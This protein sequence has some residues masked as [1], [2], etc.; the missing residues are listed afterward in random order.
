[1][2]LKGVQVLPEVP[3]LAVLQICQGCAREST[4]STLSEHTQK[5]PQRLTRSHTHPGDKMVTAKPQEG[6]HRSLSPCS[7]LYTRKHTLQNRCWLYPQPWQ[8]QSRT[9]GQKRGTGQDSASAQPGSPLWG[10]LV[11]R[12]AACFIPPLCDSD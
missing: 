10:C 11:T 4:V 2:K 8:K 3:A 12:A 7:T 1:M 5:S 6:S 9:R